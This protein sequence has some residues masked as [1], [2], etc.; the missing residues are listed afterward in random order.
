[1]FLVFTG[2]CEEI[3]VISQVVVVRAK[4]TADDYKELSLL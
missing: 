3:G 1:M 4:G 2:K